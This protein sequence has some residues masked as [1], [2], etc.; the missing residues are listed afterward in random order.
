[1]DEDDMGTD[2]MEN[3]DVK[4]KEKMQPNYLSKKHVYRQVINNPKYA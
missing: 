1:M 3:T 4:E 2:Y